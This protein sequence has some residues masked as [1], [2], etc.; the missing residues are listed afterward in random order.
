MKKV[1]FAL[2][3]AFGLASGSAF[4]ASS[5]SVTIN[6]E[7]VGTTCEIDSGTKDQTITLAKVGAGDLAVDAKVA[8]LRFDIKLT[9]CT[10]GSSVSAVFSADSP[11]LIDPVAGTLKNTATD[12][13]AT[14][15]NIALYRDTGAMIRLGTQ[16][17]VAET[18]KVAD[19][20]TGDITLTYAAAYR[21][22]GVATPGKVTAKA[23]YVIAYQ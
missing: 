20:V 18:A 9:G 8:P 17:Y 15:V 21:A 10:P 2:V 7:V 3:L 19:A 1:P 6:G 14:N 12:D 11:T 23:N 5:G 4:A 22:T 16:A 13:P